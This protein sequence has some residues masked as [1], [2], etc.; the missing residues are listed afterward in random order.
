MDEDFIEWLS[1][2][3]ENGWISQPK[4]LTHEGVPMRDWEEFQTYEQDEDPCLLASRVWVD[5]YQDVTMA[6]FDNDA[7]S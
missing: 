1:V 2:G 4:C 3:I 5:G 7:S 6:D